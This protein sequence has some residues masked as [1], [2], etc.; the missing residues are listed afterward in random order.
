[1]NP[2]PK[3]QPV[4][5]FRSFHSTLPSPNLKFLASFHIFRYFSIAQFSIELLHM[6]TY[7]HK[8]ASIAPDDFVYQEFI[9][10]SFTTKFAVLLVKISLYCLFKRI[11]VME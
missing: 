2:T 9:T 5:S 11:T 7:T 8:S 6:Q 3:R 4:Q 10:F 1:M